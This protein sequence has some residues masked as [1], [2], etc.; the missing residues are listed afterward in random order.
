MVCVWIQVTGQSRWRIP[1]RWSEESER[2]RTKRFQ[3]T[4]YGFG[5][6]FSLDDRRICVTSKH[7]HSI[8]LSSFP[9][10]HFRIHHMPSQS[11]KPTWSDL[12]PPPI[13]A[14]QWRRRLTAVAS[15]WPPACIS[16]HTTPVCRQ[17]LAWCPL[18]EVSWSA[19]IVGGCSQNLKVAAAQ[20]CRCENY[21][22]FWKSWYI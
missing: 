6:S 17:R 4:V 8:V 14:S 15:S 22:C 7:A 2:A 12:S 19:S 20:F 5:K 21:I 13:V 1:D 9:Y 10:K 3:I 18:R 11:K 16:Q